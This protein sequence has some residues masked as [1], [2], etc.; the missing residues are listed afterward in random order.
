MKQDISLA[1]NAWN[2]GIAPTRPGPEAR[3]MGDDG[4]E[5]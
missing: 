5:Y 2:N 3:Q 4:A 1:V